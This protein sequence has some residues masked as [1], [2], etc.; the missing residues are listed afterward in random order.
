VGSWLS[1]PGGGG[2]NPNG[3]GKTAGVADS[4][5][6]DND[7]ERAKYEEEGKIKMLLLAAATAC[8][9]FSPPMTRT[10]TMP[11]ASPA[12]SRSVATGQHQEDRD[13]R[14]EA[15]GTRS[16]VGDGAVCCV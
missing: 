13:E 3:Q 7:L 14:E 15:G 5:N 6:I 12:R 9:Q 4:R 1:K 11:C 8:L 10:R 2:D 16:G